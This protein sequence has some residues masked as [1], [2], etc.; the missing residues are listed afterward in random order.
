[1]TQ[2]VDRREAEKERSAM[3]LDVRPLAEAVREYE[4]NMI[5][6]VIGL[7]QGDRSEAALRLGIA[8]TT[9]YRKL[10]EPMR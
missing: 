10:G 1:M 9:L 5:K 7:C 8:R 2:I 3:L 6:F 4:R